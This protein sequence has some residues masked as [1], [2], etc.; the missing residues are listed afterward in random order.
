MVDP[1]VDLRDPAKC[2][3]R[4]V[5]KPRGYGMITRNMKLLMLI[6][7]QGETIST[8]SSNSQVNSANHEGADDHTRG[9]Y[10]QRDHHGGNVMSNNS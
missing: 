10:H 3:Y 5:R 9:R 4:I 2:Q 8:K 1:T 7:D 6:T